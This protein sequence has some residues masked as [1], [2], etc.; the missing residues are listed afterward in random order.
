MIQGLGNPAK[1]HNA[2][3]KLPSFLQ[4]RPEKFNQLL[5]RTKN[6][7]LTYKALTKKKDLAG[8]L[9]CQVPDQP[10]DIL[11]IRRQK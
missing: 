9:T 7:G 2:V 11:I 1:I 5:S 8:F 10:E 6:T 4:S 3:Y